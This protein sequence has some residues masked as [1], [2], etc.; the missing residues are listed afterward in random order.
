MGAA[1]Y[2]GTLPSRNWQVFLLPNMEHVNLNFMQPYLQNQGRVFPPT[3]E[4]LIE[5]NSNNHQGL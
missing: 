3:R 1:I 4:A 2:K 5:T